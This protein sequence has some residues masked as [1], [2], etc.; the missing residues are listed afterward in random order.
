MIFAFY[1]PVTGFSAVVY[2]NISVIVVYLKPE[3]HAVAAR[4]SPGKLSAPQK[5]TDAVA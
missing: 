2:I 5:R 3:Y 4:I 1:L